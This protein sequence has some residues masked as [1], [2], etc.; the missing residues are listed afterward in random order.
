MRLPLTSELRNSPGP[1]SLLGVEI[2]SLLLI[3]ALMRGSGRSTSASPT[4][5][6]RRDEAGALIASNSRLKQRL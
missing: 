1:F 2:A 6:E 5:E 4:T 3:A